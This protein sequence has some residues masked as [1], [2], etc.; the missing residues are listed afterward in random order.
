MYI[1]NKLS[2]YDKW[3]FETVTHAH[4]HHVHVNATQSAEETP[5]T[6]NR[7]VKP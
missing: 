4:A 2:S 3:F 6:K 5:Y 7:S 1:T